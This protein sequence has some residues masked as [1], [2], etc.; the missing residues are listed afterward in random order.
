MLRWCLKIFARISFIVCC[1]HGRMWVSIAVQLLTLGYGTISHVRRWFGYIVPCKGHFHI[2]VAWVAWQG[3]G[4]GIQR[5]VAITL[6]C[7]Q[8]LLGLKTRYISSPTGMTLL[9]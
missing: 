4:F 3:D 7:N 5:G 1:I 9:L 2:A 8:Y 6:T